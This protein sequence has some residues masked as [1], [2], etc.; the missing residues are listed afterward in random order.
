MFYLFAV[1][2]AFGGT[3]LVMQLLMTLL[4][5]AGHSLHMD[6]PSGGLDHGGDGELHGGDAHGGDLHQDSDSHHSGNSDNSGGLFRM[7]SVRSIV[8]AMAFFGVA[9]L[10]AQS[11][12]ASPLL[13]LLVA[14]GAGW[15]ALYAVFQMMQALARLHWE[16]NVRIQRAVGLPASVYL[17][18]PA[19]RAGQG[20]V[21]LA[22]QNR[23]MEYA[24]ITAGP[25][26]PTGSKV[27][28]LGVIGDDTLE[29]TAL[30]AEVAPCEVRNTCV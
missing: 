17:R 11:S 20:K 29:V 22:L 30:G 18:I 9:G 28:V 21:Q 16:G 25:E 26:L 3:V 8:A 23:T 12:G 2:L 6:L 5:M 7:L 24:A 27:V 10:T 4:G 15:M 13:Q 19:A 14:L 1:C